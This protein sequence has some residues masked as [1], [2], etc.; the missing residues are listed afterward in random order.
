LSKKTTVL[1]GFFVAVAGSILSLAT[2]APAIHAGTLM[3]YGT[4]TA[5]YTDVDGM[6]DAN[7][8]TV[9]PSGNTLVPITPSQP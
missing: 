1:R 8:M 2:T 5:A 3:T 9:D 7:A 4:T 6:V